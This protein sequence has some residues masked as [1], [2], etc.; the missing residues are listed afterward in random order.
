MSAESNDAT[1]ADALALRERAGE[2]LERKDRPDWDE[3]KQAELDAWLAESPA[4]LIAYWRVEGAWERSLRLRAVRLSASPTDAS[5]KSR[6]L[7]LK[8]VVIAAGAVMGAAAVALFLV[9]KPNE[10]VITT[11]IG[12]RKIVSLGDGSRVELNTD[13]N[14][15]VEISADRRFASIQKGEA[16]FQIAHDPEHPF[17]VTAGDHRITVLGTKFTVRREAKRLEVALLQ[18]RIWLDENVNAHNAHGMLLTPGDKVVAVGDRVNKTVEPADTLQN[19]L[20]WRRGIL[21]FKY[22]TLADAAAEFNRY[23]T[24]KIVIADADAAKL[25]IIGSFPTKDVEMFVRASRQ[26]FNLHID[27]RRN[28]IVLAR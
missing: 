1:A 14:L 20:G 12:E 10:H 23:N 21:I 16:Y 25:K 2:W 7:G 24:Q 19:E 15:R 13:T 17:V 11:G 28:E 27:H 5:R 3:D 4:N 8:R 18:G 6:S 9:A 22:T 26:L